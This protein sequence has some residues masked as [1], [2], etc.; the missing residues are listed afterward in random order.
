MADEEPFFAVVGVD[1]PAGDAVDSV[2]N[3]FAC[4]LEILGHVHVGV[5]AIFGGR[6][7]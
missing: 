2:A 1:E 5:H 3:D 4:I 7:G 6:R